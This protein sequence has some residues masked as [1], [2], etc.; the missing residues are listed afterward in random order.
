MADDFNV[1]HPRW[2]GKAGVRGAWREILGLLQIRVL[3]NTV[4]TLTFQRIMRKG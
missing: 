2:I 4:G 1:A 3:A